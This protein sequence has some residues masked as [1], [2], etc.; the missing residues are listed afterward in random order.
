MNNENYFV[1]LNQ[2]KQLHNLI[3]KNMTNLITSTTG[4]KEAVI[5][6]SIAGGYRSTISQIVNNGIEIEKDFIISKNSFKSYE[7]AAK[8]AIKNI[9]A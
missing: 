3:H 4:K 6:Y 5:T 2:Q 9:K 8:W 7:S 1:P